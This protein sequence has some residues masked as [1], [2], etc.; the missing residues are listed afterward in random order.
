MPTNARTTA[1]AALLLTTAITVSACGSS[2]SPAGSSVS[3]MAMQTSTSAR[4]EPGGTPAPGAHNAADVAFATQMIPHHRQAVQMAD[5]AATRAGAPAVKDLAATIRAA[6]APEITQMTGWLAGWAAPVPTQ[7][8]MGEMGAGAMGSTD[9]GMMSDQDM[10]SMSA[11]N[12]TAFDTA[13]LTGMTAH[14][15]GAIAMA[16]TELASGSN[17]E[18]KKLAQSVITSQGTEITQMAA[19]LKQAQ[20]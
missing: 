16:R 14:H 18:A 12:G 8:G 20:G 5:L 7:T 10:T 15:Q 4:P 3:G 19:L 13:F 17:A 1:L 11:K 9:D 2:T 6:Q